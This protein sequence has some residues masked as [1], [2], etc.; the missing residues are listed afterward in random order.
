[1]NWFNYYGLIFVALIMIPNI[2]YGIMNKDGAVNTYK[3]KIV[4]MLEQIGRYACMLFMIFNIPYTWT[5]FYFMFGETVYIIVNAIL[6]IAYCIAWLVTWKRSGIVKAL[7]LSIIPSMMFI[8]SGIMIASIPLIIFSIIFASTHILISVKNALSE[9]T[10]TKTNKKIA[11]TLISI[12]LTIVF[13]A[14]GVFGGII[15]FQQG[16]LSK[17]DGMTVMDM[18]KYC[19]SGKDKK[20]SVAIIDNGEIIY[21]VFGLN[22]EENDSIYDYEIGSISKTYVGLLCAKAISE[23]KLN[24][25]DSISNYLDLGDARYYST[26]ERLLTHTSGYKPYYFDSKMIGNKLAQITNDFYG[27]SRENVLKTVKNIDLENKDY[28]FEYSNFGISVLGLVLEKIYNDSFTNIM[29]N[30]ISNELSLHNTHVASQSGNLSGYWKWGAVDGYIP[31]GSIISNINDMASYLNLYMSNSK[32]Y[33]QM[34]YAKIKEIN[35]N[36]PVYEKMNIRMDSVGMTWMIDELNGIV[37]HNGATTDFNSYIGFTKDKK[38]GVVILSNLNANE[39]IS[40]SVIGAK[41]LVSQDA[42]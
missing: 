37:W 38:K 5:G 40:M 36:N 21:R 10:S 29:N 9:E 4:I 23:G 16:Q 14:I 12:I 3:N 19:S 11:I 34:T 24:L 39:K 20:I 30:Y 6:V 2:V 31:A 25:D 27:I 18:L 32:D 28:P 7:L 22:G 35:A 33:S 15:I 13:I 8:F 17:L 42:L 26:I 1:M 41:L